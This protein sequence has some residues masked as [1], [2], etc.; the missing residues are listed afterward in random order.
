M[1]RN[2]IGARLHLFELADWWE[3]EGE[4]LA[5]AVSVGP[6]R[7][8]QVNFPPRARPLDDVLEAMAGLH[9]SGFFRSVISALDCLGATVVGVLA[10]PVGILR[11]G[12]A[13]AL[14]ALNPAQARAT[15]GQQLQDDFRQLLEGLL[16]AAGPD[17]WFPWTGGFR[18]ML[19]HRARRLQ[20]S[21][22]RPSH[23]LYGWDG[24]PILRTEI[25]HHLAKDRPCPT[26]KLCSIDRQQRSR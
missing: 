3:R 24:R 17:A 23:T 21:Q 6:Q 25:V 22:L 15:A 4:F 16:A 2:L 9:L 1:S 8:L 19:A 14:T 18:N 20:I 12:M 10:L 7:G 11:S 13:S 26:W 5:G